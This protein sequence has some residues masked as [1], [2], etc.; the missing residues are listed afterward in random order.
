MSYAMKNKNNVY[1]KAIFAESAAIPSNEINVSNA[2]IF[3]KTITENT[4][5][6][7]TGVPANHTA[8]FTLLLTNGGS[9]VV[10]WPN[11]KWHQGTPPDLSTSGTDIITFITNDAGTNWYGV[12]VAQ[13][14]A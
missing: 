2:S 5:F 3:T 7:F 12:F 10:T 11:V 6:T 13:G 9:A 8:S 14:V 4:T 1:T